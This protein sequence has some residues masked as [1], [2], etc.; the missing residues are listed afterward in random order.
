MSMFLIVTS[1]ICW[2]IV[3]ILTIRRDFADKTYGM[4]LAAL[5]I[6]F[7]WE[8]RYSLLFYNPDIM[9][10]VQ[11]INTVW[12]A[13]DVVIVYTVF[14]FGADA[15]QRDHR[16]ALG[17]PTFYAVFL[18]ALV[19]CFIFIFVAPDYFL[20]SPVYGDDPLDVA[21]FIAYGQ[22]LLMSALFLGMY[23]NRGNIEGQSFWI[24]FFKWLGTFAVMFEY[25]PTHP[26]PVMWLVLITIC[27]LDIWYMVLMWKGCKKAGINPLKRW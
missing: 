26:Y 7:A 23:W 17:K 2:T 6:N 15:F 1:G 22:N 25:L 24:A 5:A 4:P 12:A 20:Q 16:L 3:Y 8:V 10:P 21:K 13:F 9:L 27:V 19:F 14:K 18:I 11:I